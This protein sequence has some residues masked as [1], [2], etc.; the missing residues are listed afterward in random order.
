M[1]KFVL[2]AFAG[3]VF[4]FAGFSGYKAYEARAMTYQETL[5]TKNI[6]ALTQNE[7]GDDGWVTCYYVNVFTP[8]APATLH[9]TNCTYRY[10]LGQPVA[11]CPK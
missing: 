4:C 2:M 11:K 6:E 8:D 1:K 10:G 9:C 7:E 5:M 3:I